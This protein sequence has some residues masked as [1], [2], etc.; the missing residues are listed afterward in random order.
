MQQSQSQFKY[1]LRFVKRNENYIRKESLA[2]KL[3][4]SQSGNFLKEIRSMNHSQ[5][6]VPTCVEGVSGRDNITDM[7]RNHFEALFN[8]VQDSGVEHLSFDDVYS[9]LTE[10]N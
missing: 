4:P 8:C 1:A 3:I 7:W 10:F 9:D 2:K 5:A 6:P